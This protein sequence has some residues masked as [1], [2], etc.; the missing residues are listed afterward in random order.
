MNKNSFEYQDRSFF[1]IDKKLARREAFTYKFTQKTAL[2][3]VLSLL[4]TSIAV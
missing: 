1:E 4:I 3:Q 2:F